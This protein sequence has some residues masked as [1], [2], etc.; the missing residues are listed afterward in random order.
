MSTGNEVKKIVKEYIKNKIIDSAIM[1]NGEWGSG[2]TYFIQNELKQYIEEELKKKCIYISLYGISKKEDISKEIFIKTIP[3]KKMDNMPE[4]LKRI[5]SYGVEVG[6]IFLDKL[7]IT[8]ASVDYSNLCD[9][10]NNVL[11][12]DDLE[13]CLFT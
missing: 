2:K 4:L 8:D 5:G 10:S 7:E 3:V 6:K 12:F 9:L 1:I 13:R 11:I